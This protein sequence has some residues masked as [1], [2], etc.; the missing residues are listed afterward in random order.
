MNKKLVLALILLL[1]FSPQLL[2]QK[3]TRT[4][5]KKRPATSK[6][7]AAT[8]APTPA[9]REDAAAVAEQL[10]IVSRF[11]YLYGRVA[12][13]LETAEAQEKRGELSR[14]LLEQNKQNKAKVVENIR[15]LRVGLD[16][17][18]TRFQN[19][20]K[21]EPH[22]FRI[23]NAANDAAA[24]EQMALAGRF[25]DAGRALVKVA[26]RLAEVLVEVR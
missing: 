12:S 22:A 7:R 14:A 10:R 21:L 2:A 9:F 11:L 24:A 6:Q 18:L 15:G 20:S 5:Q 26:E 25:D 16:Q 17:L 3:R 1:L 23:Q 13:G 8:P 4:P 19:N